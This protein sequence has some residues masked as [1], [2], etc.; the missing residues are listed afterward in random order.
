MIFEPGQVISGFRIDEVRE[1][2]DI[3]SVAYIGRHE[4]SGARLLYLANDDEDKSFAIGFKTPPA[5]DTGVFHILE[6]S[7]LCGSEK[8][9]VKE[10]FVNLLQGSMQTFL[11]AMTFYDKTLYPVASTNDKD[12]MNLAD[13]YMDAVLHPNIYTDPNIFAQEGWHFEVA[14][15][16]PVLNGVV[17]NEMKG[18]LSDPEEALGGRV[19]EVLFPD[20]CYKWESGGKP[21][22][23]PD[24]TYETFLNEHRRHYRPDNSYIILYGNLDAS[25]MLAFLDSKYLTPWVAAHAGESDAPAPRELVAQA[26]VITEDAETTA[27]TTP[28]NEMLA[29]AYVL[30]HGHDCRTL[31]A[32]DTMLS[33]LAGT[34]ESP[35]RRALLDADLA[36]SVT[37]PLSEEL[38]QPYVTV[39]FRGLHA[40]ARE[41]AKETFEAVLRDL[42]AKGFD[43]EAFLAAI[44]RQ[45]FTLRERDFG[46]SN[47]VVY[48]MSSLSTWLYDDNAATD[49]LTF[50]EHFAALREAAGT[51]FF[52]H[53]AEELFLENPHR[54][55]VHLS[56]VTPDKD[57]A[58]AERLAAVEAA[59][60]P[61]DFAR[62]DAQLA[63]LRARQE[64]EDSP[65]ALATLP[66][67]TLED[68]GEARQRPGYHTETAPNGTDTIL[69]H[70]VPTIGIGYFTVNFPVNRIPWEDLPYLSIAARLLGRL[71]TAAHTA[72]ELDTLAL[73]HLGG[74]SFKA[75]VRGSD[76]D[77]A[78]AEPCFTAG[79]SALLPE[80]AFAADFLREILCTTDFED[81][82]RIRTTLIQWRLGLE[83]SYVN[84]GSMVARSRVAAMHRPSAA[85][86]DRMSGVG[87]YR[88]L[89]DVLDRWDEVSST[90]PAKLRGVISAVLT[91]GNRLLSIAGGREAMDAFTGAWYAPEAVEAFAAR[92]EDAPEAAFAVPELC[93]ANEA[94]TSPSNVTF[95]VQ[96]T[97]L[98]QEGEALGLEGDD[99]LALAEDGSWEV[100]RSMLN[101]DIL[102]NEVR[103]KGGAYGAGFVKD[104]YRDLA[105]YSY[106][107]PHVDETLARFAA[108]AA[109]L[110]EADVDEDELTGYI[111]GTVASFDAPVKPR[112]LVAAQQLHYI[113]GRDP[114]LRLRRRAQAL[115]TTPE[116]LRRLGRTL[117]ALVPRMHSCTIGT[118]D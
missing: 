9:P 21:S 20:T 75:A 109:W 65:E 25:E 114:D 103:V 74:Y 16:H 97:D 29:L 92:A 99:L 111:I 14:D 69:V 106:R 38:L 5:D 84:N 90:L 2:P 8:F 27:V 86:A 40:G 110:A 83:D 59:W 15:G 12:L 10:P 26:P 23:I 55:V 64:R 78:F 31:V 66:R 116:K 28:D 46:V 112:M 47:G 58:E 30:P 88:F 95:T 82:A 6:H 51:G 118:A 91:D 113:M 57:N 60:T 42:I 24:L 76:G 62:A 68:L 37:F 44:A 67:L 56:P 71:D 93:P 89:C 105:F 79:A 4:A 41:R 54:C 77:S 94:L 98:L 107:D 72:L 33:A 39:Q 49:A 102:W 80:S 96:G 52:E 104:V 117:V 3:D 36:D 87:F 85:A 43:T 32:V 61:E 18:A 11:N 7:V 50:S 19:K 100:A 63:E 73:L 34:N 115:A 81:L 108:A 13:V 35:L 101:F 45:E 17:Y 48:A 53:L 1:I 70:E 22:A